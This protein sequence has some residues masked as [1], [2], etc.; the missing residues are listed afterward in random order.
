ML[1]VKQNIIFS[2]EYCFNINKNPA[3]GGIF[4][5]ILKKCCGVIILISHVNNFS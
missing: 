1:K 4:I 5:Y 2:P 3:F